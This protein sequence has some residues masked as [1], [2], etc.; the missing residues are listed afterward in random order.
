MKYTAGIRK[1][2]EKIVKHHD[3]YTLPQF[4]LALRCAYGIRRVRVEEDTHIPE[5]RLYYIERQRNVQPLRRWEVF[6]L[7]DYYDI[8]RSL[9][10]GKSNAWS[11]SGINVGR[12]GKK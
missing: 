9:L 3:D 2:L 8:A 4:L 10:L 11:G 12:Y 6:T 5:L 7:A 1:R